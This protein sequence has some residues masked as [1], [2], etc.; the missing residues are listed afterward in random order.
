M[1]KTFI[2]LLLHEISKSCLFA[3]LSICIQTSDYSLLI[4]K[5]SYWCASFVCLF[6]TFPKDV[7]AWRW[8]SHVACR[9]PDDPF[10]ALFF[11]NI[12][13]YAVAISIPQQVYLFQIRQLKNYIFWAFIPKKPFHSETFVLLYKFDTSWKLLGQLSRAFFLPSQA[14]LQPSLFMNLFQT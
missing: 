7:A 2:I 4:Q 1:I 8:I 13:W 11:F 9:A 3:L 10:W 5:F 14:G 6:I 12:T